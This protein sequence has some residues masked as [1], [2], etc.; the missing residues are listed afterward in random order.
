MSLNAQESRRGASTQTVYTLFERI[1]FGRVKPC[2]RD[3]NE[4]VAALTASSPTRTDLRFR[5]VRVLVAEFPGR[6]SRREEGIWASFSLIPAKHATDGFRAIGADGA[7]GACNKTPL[8]NT[9]QN[10]LV[11]NDRQ[12]PNS[13]WSEPSGFGSPK[14]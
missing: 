14:R 2:V 8:E 9:G 13:P 7:N 5:V 10:P 1:S 11:I 6:T 12:R 3:L 4:P